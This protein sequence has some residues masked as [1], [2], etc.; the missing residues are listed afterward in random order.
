MTEIL[1]NQGIRAV[2]RK[3]CT[4]C[5]APG[6]LLYANLVDHLFAVEGRWS[7]R[8]CPDCGLAWLDP[9]PLPEDSNVLYA[10]YHTHDAVPDA[11][12]LQRV[13]KRGMLATSMGYR[14]LSLSTSERIGARWLGLLGP[15]REVARHAVMW[16][17]AERRGR[18]LDVG[19]GS[20]AF[21]AEMKHLG[22]RVSGVE[23]DPEAAARARSVL[24]DADVFIG[25]LEEAPLAAGSF[26]AITLS[27]VL[28]HVRDPLATLRACGRLLKEDGWLVVATP[29]A[30]SLGSR[31]FKQHWRGWEPPRHLHLFDPRSL[32]LLA[33]AA[34]F[35]VRRIA[36]PSAAAYY[37]WRDSVLLSRRSRGAGKRQ[38]DAFTLGGVLGLVFWALEYGL[39]WLGASL[40]EEVLL[41]AESPT[42]DAGAS[43]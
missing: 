15:L 16:L 8:R 26:D 36:T 25:E 3:H 22:W 5:G 27:H 10:H 23:P 43:H 24:G 17:P 33:E 37:L 18:L 41:V 9:V 14:D 7:I 12:W 29:N 39:S 1:R 21:L 2:D 13:V 28:E 4:L 42:I 11:S 32:R 38:S 6:R 20:G 30:R 35:R 31:W 40:G 19:C 34:G